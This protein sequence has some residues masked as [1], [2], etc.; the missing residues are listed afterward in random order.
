MSWFLWL[1]ASTFFSSTLVLDE[2]RQRDNRRECLCC[3]TRRKPLQEEDDTEFKEDF[4]SRYFRNY[5]A[6]AI[7]STIGKMLVLLIFAGLL[8][9]GVYGALNLTVEDTERAFIPSDSYLQDYFDAADEY[10]PD[11]V[12]HCPAPIRLRTSQLPLARNRSSV[13]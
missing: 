7:L 6:P 1:F 13:P 12:I 8:A 10:F 2:R 9:F 4:V 11:T 3:V 5:H